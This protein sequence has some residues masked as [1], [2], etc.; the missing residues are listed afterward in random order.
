MATGIKP[1]SKPDERY[2]LHK[3]LSYNIVQKRGR[4]VLV[5]EIEAKSQE[6]E[7]NFFTSSSNC[8]PPM[9]DFPLTLLL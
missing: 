2:Y 1:K 4:T 7:P 6:K 3:S 8:S 5:N 9:M